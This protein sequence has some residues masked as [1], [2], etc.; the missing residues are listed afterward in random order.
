MYTKIKALTFIT[1][2]FKKCINTND[3]IKNIQCIKRCNKNT[4][5]TK[6]YIYP[7]L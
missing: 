5:K 6:N 4:Q 7:I 1:I 3:L 2:Y